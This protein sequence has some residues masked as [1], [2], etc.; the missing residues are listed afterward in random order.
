[1]GVEAVA[2]KNPNLC[3]ARLGEKVEDV[4]AGPPNAND[5]DVLVFKLLVVG[6][7]MNTAGG[8][9][10]ILKDVVILVGCIDGMRLGRDFRAK[11]LCLAHDPTEIGVHL[12]LIVAV[13]R[14]RGERK[15][16]FHTIAEVLNAAGVFEGAK[17]VPV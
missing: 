16:N 5:R 3:N 9:I 7:D 11:F 14:L 6:P 13:V 8:G 17:F 10:N 15:V 1:M 4:R 2:I 12:L